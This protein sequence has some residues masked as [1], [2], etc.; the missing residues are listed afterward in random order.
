MTSYPPSAQDINRPLV[1]YGSNCLVPTTSP[2]SADSD[3]TS[4]LASNRLWG[5][6]NSDLRDTAAI[7]DFT[8]YVSHY[9]PQADTLSRDQTIYLRNRLAG[10]FEKGGGLTDDRG[11]PRVTR[12]S[13]KYDDVKRNVTGEFKDTVD[14]LATALRDKVGDFTRLDKSTQVRYLGGI[15]SYADDLARRSESEGSEMATTTPSATVSSGRRRTKERGRRTD[16][17]SREDSSRRSDS[18]KRRK[19]R[20]TTRSTS[21]PSSSDGQTTSSSDGASTSPRSRSRSDSS[22]R[23]KKRSGRSES[24]TS[25]SEHRPRGKARASARSKSRPDKD[26]S[27]SEVTGRSKSGRSTSRSR[28]RKSRS[29]QSDSDRTIRS[30]RSDGDNVD[31]SSR[32]SKRNKRRKEGLSSKR[33]TRGS[34]KTSTRKGKKKS[35]RNARSEGDDLSTKST[36]DTPSRQ[37]SSRA[38]SKKSKAGR[39]KKKRGKSKSMT[40]TSAPAVESFV[41]GTELVPYDHSAFASQYAPQPTFGDTFTQPMSQP[42]W[43]GRVPPTFNSALPLDWNTVGEMISHEVASRLHDISQQWE[44]MQAARSR[45]T[46]FGYSGYPCP[47]ATPSPYGHGTPQSTLPPVSFPT[48]SMYHP[49]LST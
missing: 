3:R 44:Q 14:D 18:E 37:R 49:A 16:R 29:S 27:G 5:Q 9:L 30:S 34:K 26:D 32:K 45:A 4:S 47:P 8:D 31:G 36:S 39:N 20:S 25:D 13:R 42:D 1:P 28:P 10:A 43:L 23:N 12:D 17:S 15:L 22:T 21:P 48:M 46:S 33:S 11:Q 38:K 7:S 19:S 6:F 35:K 41:P 2:S 40:S 24:G